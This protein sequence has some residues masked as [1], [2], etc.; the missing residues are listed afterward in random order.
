MANVL[1]RLKEKLERELDQ[2]LLR[3]EPK[4]DRMIELLEEEVRILREVEKRLKS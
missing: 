3:L 1:D 2:R 4:L